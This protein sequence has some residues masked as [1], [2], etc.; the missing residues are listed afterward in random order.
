MKLAIAETI[1]Q[2]GGDPL[3]VRKAKNELD[4]VLGKTRNGIP[5]L[6]GKSEEDRRHD[7]GGLPEGCCPLQGRRK[8]VGEALDA[9]G[10]KS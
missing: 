3:T 6:V 7:S 1:A 9:I 8:T 4:A 2:I 10:F 5:R